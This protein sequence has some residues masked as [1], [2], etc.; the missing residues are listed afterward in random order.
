VI[1]RL[2]HVGNVVVDL[3]AAVPALPARGADV[4]A[5]DVVATAGGGFNVLA[6]A[7]RLGLPAVYA[8]P[9]G[10][11]P[12]AAVAT[13]ALRA[14]GV[15]VRQP[16]RP[17]DTGVVITVVDGEGERTFVT[18]PASIVGASAAELA[19]ADP[20][21][22]DAVS[23]SGYE[24]LHGPTRAALLPWVAALP[25][26]VA[27]VFDP[28]PLAPWSEPGA[29]AALRERADWVTANA[30]E[31]ERITGRADPAAAARAL[32]GRAGALVRT[33]ADGCWVAAGG[34]DPVHVPGVAV[35]VVDTTGAGDAHTGAFVAAL[36]GGADPVAAAGTA[37]AA[38]AL[39]VTR[40]GPATGPT[41]AEL[42]A[43]LSR[44]RP[45]P[46][47]AGR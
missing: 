1:T 10:T 41:A 31:A 13:A 7:A 26:E 14:E 15:E 25:A 2:V 22:G 9:V 17:A 38:G 30:A 36:A 42:A 20:R 44:G 47:P 8:G 27:V 33:G 5:H 45:R 35:E 37:N 16:A 19:A 11:G 32:R 18:S 12:F 46:G 39:A 4:L 23:V 3:V 6:A 34:A 40:R 28:G 21:P 29:V 43:F 24:V